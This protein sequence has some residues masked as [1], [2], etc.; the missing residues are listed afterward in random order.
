ME[1]VIDLSLTVV[2]CL[3]YVMKLNDGK[4]S[5][6]DKILLAVVFDVYK[7][8]NVP[9]FGLSFPFAPEVSMDTLGSWVNCD[10]RVFYSTVSRMIKDG[11]IVVEN[12]VVKISEKGKSFLAK[13]FPQLF[14]K[15]GKWDGNWRI[16]VFNIKET[17][18]F[19]R[20]KLRNYLMRIK[21]VP[22]SDG[23]WV[24]ALKYIPSLPEGTLYIEGKL[25]K[26]DADGVLKKLNIFE[27][28]KLY[29]SL[30][31]DLKKAEDLHGY[32]KICSLKSRF[33]EIMAFDP[34]L[35]PELLP[36]DWMGEKVKRKIAS[37]HYKKN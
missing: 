21:F 28:N 17:E 10:R 12:S 27:I 22:I 32:D 5:I 19:K 30:Y 24:S 16:I 31:D 33:L 35:P 9:M 36:N 3:I 14:L 8:Q 11:L 18:R 6:K 20:D 7:G 1:K 23:V 2:V 29:Q 15:N 13:N 4:L 37:L 26:Q 34:Q 25:Q